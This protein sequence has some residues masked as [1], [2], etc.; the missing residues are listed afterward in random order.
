VITHDETL[1][2]LARFVDPRDPPCMLE[3]IRIMAGLS[4]VPPNGSVLL[5]C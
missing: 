2:I 4:L 5:L 3:S 1:M